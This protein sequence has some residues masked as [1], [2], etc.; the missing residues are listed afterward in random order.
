MLE[1]P[2]VSGGN[3][4]NR[5]AIAANREANAAN[6][7]ANAAIGRQC[8]GRA[9]GVLFSAR[10]TARYM[11]E[12]SFVNLLHQSP[13]MNSAK[14]TSGVDIENEKE[15]EVTAVHEVERQGPAH[16]NETIRALKGRQMSMIAIGGAIGEQSRIV[17]LISRHGIDHWLWHKSLP[18]WAGK[19]LHRVSNHGRGVSRRQCGTALML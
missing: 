7:E 6:R 13:V 1:L 14:E 8:S 5:E 3:A 15:Y 19:P 9:A 18:L 2:T 17:L 4:A 12:T 11:G 16:Q 10:L